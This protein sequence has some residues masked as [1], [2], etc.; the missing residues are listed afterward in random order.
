MIRKY[1]LL[2]LILLVLL[3]LKLYFASRCLSNDPKGID[4]KKETHQATLKSD[5]LPDINKTGKEV[6]AIDYD[7]SIWTEIKEASG[8]ILDL[9]YASTENFTKSQIYDCSRCF[10]RPELAKRIIEIQK[11]LE[12]EFGYGLI[13]FDCYR[14]KPAQQKLW[15]KFPDI[16]Y[17]T[18]PSKGSMHNRGLAID[19]SIVDREG[20]PLD[21]GTDFDFFGPKAHSKYKKFS[22]QILSNR[23]LLYDLMNKHDLKGIRTEWWHFSLRSVSY[24]ASDWEWP[25]DN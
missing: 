9:K 10:L 6:F 8:I 24:Q 23:S 14:P 16:N 20:L 25:C 18:P 3:G 2:F 21:M 1:A 5:A 13:L 4:P 7:T 15:D 22:N 12:T 11:E 17:V 19:L